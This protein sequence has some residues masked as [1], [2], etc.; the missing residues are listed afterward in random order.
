MLQQIII[1]DMTN[2]RWRGLV[3]GLVSA[4]F[5]INN[6][7]SAEIAE[8]VLPNWR[9]GYGMVSRQ[10]FPFNVDHLTNCIPVCYPRPSLSV[11]HH[12]CSHVG[13]AQGCQAVED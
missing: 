6:F 5:I 9:W 10:A 13:P 2:L 7:V 11:S 1:A 8:G 3:T 12:H 4:P